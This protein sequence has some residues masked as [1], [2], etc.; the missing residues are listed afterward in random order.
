MP[1]FLIEY[2]FAKLDNTIP[3]GSRNSTMSRIG[4]KIIKRYGDTTEARE[5]FFREAEMCSPPLEDRELE[6][7]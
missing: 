7:I 5:R 4:A 2:Q 1:G 3:E 6:T